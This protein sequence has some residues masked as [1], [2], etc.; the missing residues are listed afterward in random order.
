MLNIIILIMNMIGLGNDVKPIP[1]EDIATSSKDAIVYSSKSA[2][3]IIEE[4]STN[5]LDRLEFPICPPI[6]IIRPPLV[7]NVNP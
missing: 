1:T 6:P 3:D 2:K 4:V 5:P 7:T